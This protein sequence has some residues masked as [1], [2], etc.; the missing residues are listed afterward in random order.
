MRKQCETAD[1]VMEKYSEAK[2]INPAWE[3]VTLF[4]WK[5]LVLLKTEIETLREQI[6]PTGD[7][8]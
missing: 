8:E 7:S 1:E 3:R 4:S 2:E 5:D 6:T